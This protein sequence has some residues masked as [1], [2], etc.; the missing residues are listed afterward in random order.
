MR[1]CF[2]IITCLVSL[3]A[4]AQ[5]D[6]K[7]G[8]SLDIGLTNFLLETTTSD[9]L[10]PLGYTDPKSWRDASTIVSPHIGANVHYKNWTFGAGWQHKR[11]NE[12]DVELRESP[13]MDRIGSSTS[14]LSTY[15]ERQF[16]AREDVYPYFA[17]GVSH[18]KNRAF[19]RRVGEVQRSA[20]EY[21]DPFIRAGLSYQFKKAVLRID[22]T[23]RFTDDEDAT[24]LIRLATRFSFK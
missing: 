1:K 17:V 15:I 23:R 13:Y 20:V 12:I 19:V 22:M 4:L 14:W 7:V 2:L 10:N 11:S 5:D 6:D 9:V 8:F 21:T 24:N 16:K 3:N 18:A